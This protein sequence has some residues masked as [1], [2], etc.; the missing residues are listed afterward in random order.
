MKL[1]T[2]DIDYAVRA[3]F[4]IASSKA[5]VVSA[6]Q[7]VKELKISRAFLRK[8]LQLLSKHN[9]LKSVKGKGGGFSLGLPTRKIFLNDLM[10]IFHGRLTFINCVFNNKVCSNKKVCPLRKKI[11]NIE[12][13]VENE[14]KEISIHSLL[15]TS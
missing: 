10:K 8:I 13:H 11:K 5:K 6:A 7:L 3:L 4:Y 2:K 9:I 15:N 1:V 12:K 14:L